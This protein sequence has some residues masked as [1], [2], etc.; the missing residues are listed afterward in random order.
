[1]V[2]AAEGRVDSPSVTGRYDR[3]FAYAASMRCTWPFEN[4][5][6]HESKE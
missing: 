5:F 1:M 4:L 3:H 6:M 2:R